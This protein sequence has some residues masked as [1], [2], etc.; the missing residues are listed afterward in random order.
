MHT[1][2]DC[3]IGIPFLIKPLFPLCVFVFYHLHREGDLQRHGTRPTYIFF[4]RAK[5]EKPITALALISIDRGEEPPLGFE[6]VARTPG[7]RDANL[8]YGSRA[9]PPLFLCIHRGDG[10]PI[11]D[12]G[13][14]HIKKEKIPAGWHQ[15]SRTPNGGTPDLDAGQT[16]LSYKRDYKS[17]IRKFRKYQESGN[18]SHQ[19]LARCLA[20]LVGG[21]YSYDRQTFLYAL[22]AFTSLD[23]IKKFPDGILADFVNL[24]RDALTAYIS[25]FNL[26]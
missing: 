5:N 11:T 14:V 18:P 25:Y 21:I 4:R 7:S 1:R 9:A 10:P 19:L 12:I 22:E 13:I 20:C 16:V 23:S 17:V 3:W 8:T 6:M 26:N 15:I 24:V 2:V